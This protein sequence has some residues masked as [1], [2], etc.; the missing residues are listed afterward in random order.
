MRSGMILIITIE[1][2]QVAHMLQKLNFY[3]QMMKKN[4]TRKQI[5]KDYVYVQY[6]NKTNDNRPEDYP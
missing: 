6:V 2:V 5:L 4:C 1:Q 3:H